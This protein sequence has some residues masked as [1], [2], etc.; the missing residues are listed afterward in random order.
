MTKR[1]AVLQFKTHH[2]MEEYEETPWFCPKCGQQSVWAETCGG[3]YYLGVNHF[4][5]TCNVHFYLP[6]EPSVRSDALGE[7]PKQLRTGIVDEVTT[8]KGN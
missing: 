1:Q 8:P 6:S 4:C 2:Y 5:L 7:I 3:D